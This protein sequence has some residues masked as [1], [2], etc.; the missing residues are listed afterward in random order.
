MQ[1]Y[2]L[3]FTFQSVFFR[4]YNESGKPE[5]IDAYYMENLVN[6]VKCLAK[7]LGVEKFTLVIHSG[8]RMKLVLK[9]MKPFANLKWWSI[10]K[11][12]FEIQYSFQVAHDWGGGVA[13]T[14]AALHPEMLSNLVLTID[15]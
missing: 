6:D 10:L 15:L 5:G 11:Y 2:T 13:W 14:F 12:N 3:G 7:E 9:S 4:G 8:A 1:K